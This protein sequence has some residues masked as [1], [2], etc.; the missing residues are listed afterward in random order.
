MRNPIHQTQRQSHSWKRLFPESRPWVPLLSRQLPV[1]WLFLSFKHDCVSSQQ[2]PKCCS[3]TRCRSAGS[4][5]A[6]QLSWLQSCHLEGHRGGTSWALQG[7]SH[8]RS[9]CT[10][11]SYSSGTTLKPQPHFLGAALWQPHARCHPGRSAASRLPLPGEGVGAL[12]SRDKQIKELRRKGKCRCLRENQH[13][14][15]KLPPSIISLARADH[16]LSSQHSL[17]ES[18]SPEQCLARRD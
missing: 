18:L 6:L 15:W 4:R 14:L 12:L 16:T 5:A 8:C 17:L 10:H 1:F 9:A 3:S 13:C 2:P 11:L 7:D